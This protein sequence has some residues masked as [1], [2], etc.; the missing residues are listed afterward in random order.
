MKK[1]LICCVALTTLLCAGVGLSGCVASQ[2]DHAENDSVDSEFADVRY[3]APKERVLVAAGGSDE[4]DSREIVCWGDSM[5]EGAGRDSAAITTGGG[6]FDASYLSYPEVLQKLTGIT[7]CNFGVSGA[8][9]EEIGIMQGGIKANRKDASIVVDEEV[10]ELAKRHPGTIL[11]LEIG[12]NGGWGGDYA[13]LI[14]Q[15]R[16][17]IK[18]S[19]CENFIIIGDTDDPGTSYGDWKQEAFEPGEGGRQTDWETALAAEFGDHF[20][21][22]R[23]FLIEDGLETAGLVPT[24]EDA[25]DAAAGCISMQLRSDWTHLNSYGYYAKAQAVYQR[26]VQL[27]Y[28]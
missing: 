18:N 28:W 4:K 13:T 1:P 5:T 26:G 25:E 23:Q 12:S 14:E 10:V 8:T 9:S 24:D 6:V 21:N 15:Y 16:A 3:D 2:E 20:I 27:G 11:V 17:I 22:M 19:G 7:T